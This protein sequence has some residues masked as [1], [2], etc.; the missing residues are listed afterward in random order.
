M[1]KNIICDMQHVQDQIELYMQ[2]Y[3]EALSL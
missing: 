1:N 3:E 2:S